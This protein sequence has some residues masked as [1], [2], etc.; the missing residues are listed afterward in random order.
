MIKIQS[1]YKI[2]KSNHIQYDGTKEF[3]IESSYDKSSDF[4]NFNGDCEIYNDSIDFEPIKDE[5]R[6]K[7]TEDLRQDIYNEIEEERKSIIDTANKKATELL[8]DA[9]GRGFDAGFKEGFEQG[10]NRGIDDSK[11]EARVIKDNAIKT[12]LD[13]QIYVEDYF[14][15]NQEQLI[16]FAADMAEAIVHTTIN[17]SSE[18]IM[19][20]LKPIL[21]EFKKTQNI[22]ISCHPESL[23]YIKLYQYKMEELCANATFTI[24]GDANLER[25]GCIIENDNQIIDAQI[26]SQLESVLASIKDIETVE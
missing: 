11:S 15:Q 2:I 24:I 7:L 19:M 22:I 12:M 6:I 16:R 4:Y 14:V 8:E 9:K 18:N 25:F 13:A 10:Y 5:L 17:E 1:S 3:V 20:I 21:L 26:K 23:D